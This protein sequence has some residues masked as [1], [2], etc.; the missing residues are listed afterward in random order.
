VLTKTHL[1]SERFQSSARKLDIGL[2]KACLMHDAAQRSGQRQNT[3][4]IADLRF[5][6]EYSPSDK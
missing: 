6:R 2:A 1:K 5:V 3:N 4:L